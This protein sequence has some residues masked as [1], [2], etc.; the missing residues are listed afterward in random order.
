MDEQKLG[1]GGKENNKT[2]TCVPAGAQRTEIVAF[3]E[4]FGTHDI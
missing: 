4:D 1:L 3:P 2:K